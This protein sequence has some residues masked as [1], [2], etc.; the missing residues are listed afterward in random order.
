M[1]KSVQ[2]KKMLKPISVAPNKDGYKI[3]QGNRR[4]YGAKQAGLKEIP[5]RIIKK[6]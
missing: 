6:T 1:A 3:T 5:C 2:S 4:Y